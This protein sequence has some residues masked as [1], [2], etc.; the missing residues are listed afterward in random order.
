MRKAMKRMRKVMAHL[1]ISLLLVLAALV[2]LDSFNPAIGFLNSG[3]AKA[4]ELVLCAVGLFT[5]VS[6][7]WEER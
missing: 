3:V 7:A 2:I 5:A 6:T 1:M 4:F